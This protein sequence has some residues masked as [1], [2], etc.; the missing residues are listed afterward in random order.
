M[1]VPHT[2][3]KYINALLL[4]D[5]LLINEIYKNFSGLVKNFV[6]KNGGSV[7]DAADIMQEGLMAIY[8]KARNTD[9]VLTCPFEAFL[10]MVCK[11]LWL[12]QLRKKSRQPVTNAGDRQYELRDDEIQQTHTA[13]YNNERYNLLEKSYSILGE[14]CK[15][16]LKLAWSGK[17]LEEVARL[18]NNS[19]GYI[20]KKKSECAG[21]LAELIKQSPEYKTLAWQ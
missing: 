13:V 19:Y 4:N 7:D 11:N 14:S 3:T 15:E 12:M 17:P 20:R 18:M 6:T 21:K 8:H 2:D 5:A 10:F 9:F 16:L 1:L